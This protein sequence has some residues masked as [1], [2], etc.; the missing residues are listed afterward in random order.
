MLAVILCWVN[1][2]FETFLLYVLSIIVDLCEK[3]KKKNS[4]DFMWFTMFMNDVKEYFF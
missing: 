3:K 4:K 1:G 2:S